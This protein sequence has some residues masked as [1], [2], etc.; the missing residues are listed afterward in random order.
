MER[1]SVTVV[2]MLTSSTING[3]TASREMVEL[4]DYVCSYKRCIVF[5]TP[6]LT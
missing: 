2:V 1:L 4:P 3:F 5:I 6:S